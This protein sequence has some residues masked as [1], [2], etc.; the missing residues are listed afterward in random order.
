MICFFQYELDKACEKLKK[1]NYLLKIAYKIV[2][3]FFYPFMKSK[4]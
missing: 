1:K 3:N 2:V 4:V